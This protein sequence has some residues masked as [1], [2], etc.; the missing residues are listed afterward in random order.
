MSLREKF[1]KFAMVVAFG[2]ALISGAPMR[3]EQVDELLFQ[4]SQ[5]KLAHIL[6][7]EAESDDDLEESSP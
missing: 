1:R 7:N 4:I 3:P 6:R 5:P 2:I